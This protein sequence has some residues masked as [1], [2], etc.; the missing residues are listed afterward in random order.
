[1]QTEQGAEGCRRNSR[2]WHRQGNC[3]QDHLFIICN[4]SSRCAAV[5]DGLTVTSVSQ[6]MTQ[7][8]NSDYAVIQNDR[9]ERRTKYRFWQRPNI[10]SLVGVLLARCTCSASP[11]GND[12]LQ[13]SMHR[14]G[15]DTCSP[16]PGGCGA[17]L[18]SET[19][20][21]CKCI[22]TYC[23]DAIFQSCAT[24]GNCPNDFEGCTPT[25][26][27]PYYPNPATGLCESSPNVI[28]GVFTIYSTELECCED[29]YSW[30]P[31]TC[32]TETLAPSS[33]PTVLPVTTEVPSS[34]LRNGMV[35]PEIPMRL[36]NL[37]TEVE[38][39]NVQ[40][41][42]VKDSVR[43]AAERGVEGFH[44]TILSVDIDDQ[45]FWEDR[46]TLLRSE[47]TFIASDANNQ[48][49]LESILTL[50]V[51]ITV[52]SWGQSPNTVRSRVLSAMQTQ[53]YQIADTLAETLGPNV[54][55]SDVYLEIEGYRTT[56]S[57]SPASPFNSAIMTT[58]K[59][60]AEEGKDS[61]KYLPLWIVIIFSFLFVV[62]GGS[63]LMWQRKRDER[64]EQVSAVTIQQMPHDRERERPRRV[65][66]SKSEFHLSEQTLKVKNNSF[67]DEEQVRN[68]EN[69]MRSYAQRRREEADQNEDGYDG[70]NSSFLYSEGAVST[71]SSWVFEA[72]RVDG[73]DVD[74]DSKDGESVLGMLYY[75]GASSSSSEDA[76]NNGITSGGVGSTQHSRRSR[77]SR[78]SARMSRRSSRS[79]KSRSTK[80]KSSNSQRPRRRKPSLQTLGEEEPQLPVRRSKPDP[81]GH[82]G[83]TIE[84]IPMQHYPT[85]ER[86]DTVSGGASIGQSTMQST[87]LSEDDV[88]FQ[89]QRLDIQ[90]NHNSNM[91]GSSLNDEVSLTVNS[92]GEFTLD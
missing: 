27:C 22:P 89:S 91:C 45:I 43:D 67:T 6:E 12:K 52:S 51:K 13:S 19:S 35:L 92:S 41:S 59:V 79:N 15:Q 71:D 85:S 29:N 37:S 61:G 56:T 70:G 36:L 14:R 38:L 73:V 46:R 32:I 78:S 1:M 18:W 64:S 48:R 57:P 54:Y 23:Y 16:P 49:K 39:N 47:G 11:Y 80:S 60:T 82:E 34:I 62:V 55:T 66:V 7:I 42:K 86:N 2:R 3:D 5:V 4:D 8:C 84:S 81:D 44:V 53:K 83:S 9:Y 72:E 68:E 28:Q 74:E 69:L 30:D 40:L 75:A 24:F 31:S 63:L 26:D 20:C 76:D 90:G 10:Y 33:R 77:S 65:R 58:P 87:I 17:G 25:V 21:E 88:F 50:W